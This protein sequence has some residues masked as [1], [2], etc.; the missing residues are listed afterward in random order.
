MPT[1]KRKYSSDPATRAR[2]LRDEGRFGGR[3]PGAGRPRKDAAPRRRAASVIAEGAREN[4]HLMAQ[5]LEDVLT[6]PE[7]TDA[8]RIRALKLAINIESREEDRQREHGS[9]D[10]HELDEA[11]TQGEVLLARALRSGR[12]H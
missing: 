1:T 3:Q 11:A 7:A 4:A 8:M 12:R 5:V 10:D 2:E 9:D 6:D